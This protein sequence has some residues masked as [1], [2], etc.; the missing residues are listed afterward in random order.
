[1]SDFLGTA[2][3]R[4]G[5]LATV[6]DHKDHLAVI[7][8]ADAGARHTVAGV[9]GAGVEGHLPIFDEDAAS[10]Y[11]LFHLILIRRPFAA[12]SNDRAS[13]FEDGEEVFVAG[14]IVFDTVHDQGTRR[15]TVAHVVEVGVD[16]RYCLVVLNVI[17]SII[18]I[19]VLLLGSL[20]LVADAL[21]APGRS[22]IVL[23]ISN[24]GDIVPRDVSRCK[25]IDNLL[26]VC[27]HRP[28]LN[29][30]D[31]R[32]KRRRLAREDLVVGGIFLAISS[33]IEPVCERVTAC[34]AYIFI[35]TAR[36]VRSL[37]R[38]YPL[39]ACIALVDVVANVLLRGSS[40]KAVV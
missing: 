1:M 5:L 39:V 18:S 27:C 21:H 9:A 7:G 23:V 30:G 35:Y 37:Q 33:E 36:K 14:A 10:S 40:A 19:A 3:C 2:A 34:L 32:S 38:N 15:S 31:A 22:V 12:R 20:H 24:Y 17:V 26:V 28:L 13:V 25:V 16:S 6:Q 4:E 11:R 29:L 8:D